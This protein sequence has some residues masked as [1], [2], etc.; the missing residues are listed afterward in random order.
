MMANEQIRIM[1]NSYEKMEIFIYL[2]SLF[3]NKNSIHDGEN[4]DNAE[5]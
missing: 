5:K 3:T 4:I 2:G 1:S